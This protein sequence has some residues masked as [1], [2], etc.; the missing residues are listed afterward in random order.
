MGLTWGVK[1]KREFSEYAG[2]A[3]VLVTVEKYKVEETFR[4][5]RSGGRGSVDGAEQQ[6]EHERWQTLHM[7]FSELRGNSRVH[8]GGGTVRFMGDSFGVVT[9]GGDRLFF[10]SGSPAGEPGGAC[11]LAR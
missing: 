11:R 1:N 3:A 4:R 9:A 8:R 6:R 7:A 2:T 5:H 10:R